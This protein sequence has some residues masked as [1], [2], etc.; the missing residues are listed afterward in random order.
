[1][2]KIKIFLFAFLMANLVFAG[3]FS[4]SVK[5]VKMTVF[6]YDENGNTILEGVRIQVET[7][8]QIQTRYSDGQ[9]RVKF[10]FKKVKNE[11]PIIRVFKRGYIPIEVPLKRNLMGNTIIKL[12]KLRKG[13]NQCRRI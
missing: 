7:S 2:K 1:M 10:K 6:T 3:I 11:I 13:G 9:G 5:R 4:G 8:L 12:K